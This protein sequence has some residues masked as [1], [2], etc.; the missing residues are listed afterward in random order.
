MTAPPL[1][2]P[3][4]PLV[5]RAVA[6]YL[7]LR[8]AVTLIAL[9]AGALGF[10]RPDSPLGIVLLSAVMVVVDVTRRR[11]Q[12]LWANLGVARWTLAALGGAVAL[13]GEIASA[14]LWRWL[15]GLVGLAP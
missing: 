13:A 11:E 15:W 3:P 10:D 5:R 2:L 12:A 6:L 14:P 8:A 1:V 9:L 7:V 4:P